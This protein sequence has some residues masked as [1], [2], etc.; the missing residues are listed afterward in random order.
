MGRLSLYE[1]EDVTPP[2]APSHLAVVTSDQG[3]DW[4]FEAC[5][6]E[7]V[8]GRALAGAGY[9][10]SDMMLE[11]CAG[12]CE[13]FRYFGAE[14][15]GEC[16]CGDAFGKGSTVVGEE[17]CSMSCSGDGGQFCGAGNRLSVYERRV[18]E[19]R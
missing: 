12:F 6:T 5:R 17:E 8:G 1:R 15:A 7:A 18:V 16:F 14:Y 13:G 9:A 3:G 11:A 2:P 19:V 10:S 4:E